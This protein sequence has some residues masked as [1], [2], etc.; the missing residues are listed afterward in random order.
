MKFSYA[1]YSDAGGRPVNED[2]FGIY[3]KKDS[4]LAL[5]ADGLGGHGLGDE[6]SQ[7]VIKA[8][9]RF[10]LEHDWYDLFFHDLFSYCNDTLLEKQKIEKVRGGMKTTLVAVYG[11]NDHVRFCHCGDSRAYLFRK[12]KKYERTLDHSIPQLLVLAGDIKEKM[13]RNH[14]DRSSLLKCLGSRWEKPAEEEGKDLAVRSGDTILLCSDGF[15]E[16]ITEQEIKRINLFIRD[17]KEKLEKMKTV[18][19]KHGAGKRMDN[20]TAILIT[21][22]GMEQ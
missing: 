15:W 22:E 21:L 4:F 1:T 18:V 12:G 20:N 2:S 9:E 3:E 13:I 17:T 7:T 5:V 19:Q 8:A 10:Y 6:A 16:L 11:S 14:P